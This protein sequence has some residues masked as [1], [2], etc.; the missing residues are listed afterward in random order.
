ML[1]VGKIQL[2]VL[3]YLKFLLHCLSPMVMCSLSYCMIIRKLFILHQI[4]IMHA[5]QIP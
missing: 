2:I 3:V 4:G 5:E 1:Q